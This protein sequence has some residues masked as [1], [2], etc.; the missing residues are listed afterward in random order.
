M[1]GF[2]GIVEHTGFAAK[3][4]RGA[5]LADCE[6]GRTRSARLP[7]A[8]NAPVR[9]W[10]RPRRCSSSSF[11]FGFGFGRGHHLLG[12]LKPDRHAI[13]NIERHR[14]GRSAGG[15]RRRRGAGAAA[16]GQGPTNSVPQWRKP[17]RSS[18]RLNAWYVF[19]PVEVCNLV[20]KAVDRRKLHRRRQPVLAVGDARGLH[21]AVRLLLGGA[22]EN[23][24]ARLEVVLVCR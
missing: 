6:I 17:P 15:R 5:G 23:L 14:I 16:F 18:K 10:Y 11:A 13:G 7:S 9:R 2:I 4:R 21:G 3:A 20:A 19:S 22:D 8:R 12:A 24:D 1:A